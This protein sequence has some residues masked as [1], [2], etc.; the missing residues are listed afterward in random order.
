MSRASATSSLAEPDHRDPITMTRFLLQERLQF[1]EATGQFAMV[2][3]SIQLACKA[4]ANATKKAGIAQLHGISTAV[5]SSGDEQ[6]KLDVFANEC[7]INCLTFSDHV[8][9]MCSEE[10]EEPIIVGNKTGGYA[11]VFDPLDGSSNIEANISVG[12]IFGIYKKDKQTPEHPSVKDLLKPGRELL[13]AGYALYG[14]A[15]ILVLSTGRGVNGFTLD[16]VLGEFILT[17]RDIRIPR[18]GKIYS[19]NEGNSESWDD[20]TRAFVQQCKKK[21]NPKSARYVGSM[22]ADVHRTLLYGGIFCYPGDVKNPDGKLRLLYECN[23]MAF[24]IEQAGGK[25]TTGTQRVLDVQPTKLH[26]RK[27]IFCGSADDV[28]MVEQFYQQYPPK[29]KPASPK[30]KL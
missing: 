28:T 13:A 16:P 6:K 21:P 9:I 1:S 7:F 26:Q 4:I 19:I 10:N 8:Y 25:A 12:T 17:H 22:V 5:N 30:A 15:T 29:P 2:L 11:I 23:P 24:L 20:A 18:Q 3:Q 14:S 27:P